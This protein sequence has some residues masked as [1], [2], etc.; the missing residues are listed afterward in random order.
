[1]ELAS[2]TSSIVQQMKELHNLVKSAFTQ[3]MKAFEDLDRELAEEAGTLSDQVENL[4]H[5]IEDMVFDTV[6][7]CQPTQPDLRKLITYA[8]TSSC[9]QK[10]GRY[11]GKIAN[12]VDYCEDMDH[13]K[14]LES[15][16]YLADLANS[17]IDASVR[18]VIDEDLSE[19]DELE[20]LEAQSDR[21]AAEMFHE[22]ADYLNRRRDISEL[23]MY[24]IIVGR[25]CERAADQAINIAEE[26][27]FMIT[28]SRI[29]LGL[30]YKGESASL[31]D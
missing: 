4:Y 27:S 23:A 7:K 25:Y 21:E 24:Y 22:I 30:A 3:A 10:V 26:A 29:K 20:K 18:A 14:E 28:G 5:Q 2:D 6:S 15:L 9:L 12:I 17:A 8:N 16:P 11:A 1:S 19:I 31:L 13:F